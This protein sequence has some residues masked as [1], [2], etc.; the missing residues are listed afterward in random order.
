MFVA[1]RWEREFLMRHGDDEPQ[2]ELFEDE[3]DTDEDYA[4]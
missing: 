3:N 4:T 2:D 1:E